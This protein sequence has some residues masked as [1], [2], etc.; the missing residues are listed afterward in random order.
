MTVLY[1]LLYFSDFDFYENYEKSITGEC[2]RKIDYGPAPCHFKKAIVELKKEK[3]IVHKIEKHKY[4]DKKQNRFISCKEPALDKLSA[5]EKVF[6]DKVINRL[7][8]MNATNM[9]SISH[10]DMPYKATKF[11][12]IINYDLVFYRDPVTTS[13]DDSDEC[14]TC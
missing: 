3:K 12:E 13:R 5:E 6:I 11:G 14:P 1:K 4:C 8:S 2:Y 7:S 10:L 9:T